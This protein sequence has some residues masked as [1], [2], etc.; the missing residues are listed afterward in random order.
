MNF[1]RHYG[2]FISVFFSVTTILRRGALWYKREKIGLMAALAA[3]VVEPD[4]GIVA[5]QFSKPRKNL[6]VCVTAV[7]PVC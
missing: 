1:I 5:A 6:R 7:R 3:R 2:S 4:L